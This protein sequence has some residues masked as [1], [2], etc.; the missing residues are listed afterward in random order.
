MTTLHL[1]VLDIPYGKQG[2]T[3]THKVASII[4]AKYGLFSMFVQMH[5][6]VISHDIENAL[7]GYMETLIMRPNAQH[8]RSKA[9]APAMSD[10]EHEFRDAIDKQ[11]YDY[12]MRGVPTQ[13]AQEGIRHSLKNPRSRRHAKRIGGKTV[14]GPRPSFFDTGLMSSSFRAW[15]DD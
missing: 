13:A 1:G 6:A 15:V 10:I 8:D 7:R 3:T 11:V 9:F 14:G 5:E 2:S 12:A 4:E